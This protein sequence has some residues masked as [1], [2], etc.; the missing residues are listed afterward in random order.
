MKLEIQTNPKVI[1]ILEKVNLEEFIKVIKKMFPED[2]K[3]YCIETGT[4]VIWNQ[5]PVYRYYDY[6]W[7]IPSNP[8]IITC[9]TTTS[10]SNSVL[11]CSNSSNTLE[12]KQLDKPKESTYLVEV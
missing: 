2:Y 1:K 8:S 12:W 9:E 4:Q 11:S 6:N 10:I 3:E 7:Y 5:Y